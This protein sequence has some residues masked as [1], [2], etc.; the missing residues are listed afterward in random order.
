MLIIIF[1]KIDD[2]MKVLIE[3]EQIELPK[4]RK[5]LNLLKAQTLSVH[6]SFLNSCF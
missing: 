4:R 6:F 3:K 5:T 2:L 1:I